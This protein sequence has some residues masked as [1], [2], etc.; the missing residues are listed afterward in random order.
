MAQTHFLITV[1]GRLSH[2][3]SPA[4]PAECETS[5]Q[6]FLI[7]D[8]RSGRIS[9]Q[10]QSAPGTA[11]ASA[12]VF[13][14]PLF[15]RKQ[16]EKRIIACYLSPQLKIECRRRKKLTALPP[17]CLLKRSAA[18]RREKNT[19]ESQVRKKRLVPGLYTVD[20]RAC[21]TKMGK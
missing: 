19:V 2:N 9:P 20:V 1:G 12:F 11:A 18:G 16:P 7:S 15:P 14:V 6:I 3:I 4:C 21:G 13:N 10:P 8:D 5:K 17:A